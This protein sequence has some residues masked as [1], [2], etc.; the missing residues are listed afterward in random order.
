[1]INKLRQIIREEIAKGYYENKCVQD[2][3]QSVGSDF[4]AIMRDYMERQDDDPNFDPR[5]ALYDLYDDL[6]FIY[7]HYKKSQDNE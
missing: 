2:A 7:E 6:C 3:E 4:V 5:Q 1:M